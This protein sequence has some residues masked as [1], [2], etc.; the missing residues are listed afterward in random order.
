MICFCLLVVAAPVTGKRENEGLQNWMIAVIAAV[1]GVLLIAIVVLVL[2]C[3]KR[4]KKPQGGR[5]I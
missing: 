2:C 4:R 1:A 5:H 3:F